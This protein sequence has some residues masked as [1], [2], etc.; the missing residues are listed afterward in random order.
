[1][2]RKKSD[3]A[4][5]EIKAKGLEYLFCEGE[6][7][8]IVLRSDY[9]GDSVRFFTPE[10]FSQQLGYHPHRKG[11]VIKP[12]EHRSTTKAVQHT[13]EVLILRK[14]RVRVDFFDKQGRPL[15][16]ETLDSGDIILLCG[17]DMGSSS[18]PTQS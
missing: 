5:K 12:H 11:D 3:K 14:G 2:I 18:L 16:S 10:S 13:Q 15:F 4:V 1:M 7:H 17:G 9:K 6:L 8:A